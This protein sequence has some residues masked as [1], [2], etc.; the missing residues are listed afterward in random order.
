MDGLC[1]EA[2]ISRIELAFAYVKKMKGI[3]HLVFGVDSMEQLKEDILLFGHDVPQEL[4]E[5]MEEEF[6]QIPAEIMMP[7]LWKR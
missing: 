2:G 1:R 7:S 4:V 6:D 3:S 5:R